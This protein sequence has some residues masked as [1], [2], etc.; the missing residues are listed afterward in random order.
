MF[1][2]LKKSVLIATILTPS[3]G[4][5]NPVPSTHSVNY[6]YEAP[7][8]SG[9]VT[10]SYF[11]FNSPS[12]EEYLNAK[13]RINATLESITSEGGTPR[14]NNLTIGIGRGTISGRNVGYD[15]GRILI[16]IAASDAEIDGVLMGYFYLVSPQSHLSFFSDA[17][18]TRIQIRHGMMLLD[19]V[20]DSFYQRG[21]NLVL[22]EQMIVA[23]SGQTIDNGNVTYT[24]RTLYISV[25]AS[26]DEIERFLMRYVRE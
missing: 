13:T 1:N 6:V 11:A 7:D 23:I 25:V 15:S 4:V 5:A 3:L 10:V 20:I 8:D 24:R 21:L 26:A 16:S 14:K 19:S 2:I 17:F 9:A 22:P 12:I 18:A